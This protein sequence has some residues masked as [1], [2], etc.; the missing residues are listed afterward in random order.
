[1]ASSKVPLYLVV[2]T[3]NVRLNVLIALT[4]MV[5]HPLGKMKAE[6]IVEWLFLP[7][8]FIFFFFSSV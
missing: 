6:I 7:L 8:F 2:S 3:P 5:I 1:M 4:L